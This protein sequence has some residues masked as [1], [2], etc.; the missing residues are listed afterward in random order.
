[1]TD[2]RSRRCGV[3][4]SD[5][6]D[7]VGRSD[8][9]SLPSRLEGSWGALTGSSPR[10]LP[11]SCREWTWILTNARRQ[12]LGSKHVRIPEIEGED[13]APRA[14]PSV[15]GLLD[16]DPP[17][18]TH[19]TRSAIGG[20]PLLCVTGSAG[21]IDHCSL[22]A[23]DAS[24]RKAV[25]LRPAGPSC[26]P[27]VGGGDPLLQVYRSMLVSGQVAEAVLG[28]MN[29]NQAKLGSLSRLES[30]CH[31]RRS[32]ANI[33]DGALEDWRQASPPRSPRIGRR[34]DQT[35]R[36]HETVATAAS[37]RG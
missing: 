27:T 12:G 34:P 19:L 26:V 33:T 10:C 1:M 28:L 23:I 32:I 25:R 9:A 20:T 24:P 22:D 31:S 7:P 35:L 21:E 13:L 4:R 11:V 30:S 5:D 8:R 14:I 29:S 17:H 36:L 15:R 16:T 37:R 18:R 3:L 2:R 6:V